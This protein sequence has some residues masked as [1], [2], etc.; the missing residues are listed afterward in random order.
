MLTA[1]GVCMGDLPSPIKV[2]VL[3]FSTLDNSA[4]AGLSLVAT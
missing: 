3:R 4:G 1:E 2:E